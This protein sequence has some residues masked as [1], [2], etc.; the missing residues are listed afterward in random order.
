MAKTQVEDRAVFLASSLLAA[1]LPLC[2]YI[3]R[4][5]NAE[6]RE[7]LRRLTGSREYEELVDLLT[8]MRR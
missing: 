3:Q 4:N 8:K 5:S 6:D 1:A 7:K 2:R